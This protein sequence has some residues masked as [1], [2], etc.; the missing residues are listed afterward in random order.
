[1]T[2]NLIS[3][4]FSL[5]RLLRSENLS[6]GDVEEIGVF[7]S[8]CS[9][10]DWHRLNLHTIPAVNEFLR[11]NGYNPNNIAD[12]DRLQSLHAR[13]VDYLKEEFQVTL[14]RVLVK[15]SR[16]QNIFLVASGKSHIQ[17]QACTL[18][19]VLHVLNHLDAR[20]LFIR[21]PVPERTLFEEVEHRVTDIVEHMRSIGFSIEHFR[22]SHK[23]RGSTLTKVLSKEAPTAAQVYDRLRFRIVAK[24]TADIVPIIYFL[25]KRLVPFNYIIPDESRNNLLATRTLL[26]RVGAE[27]DLQVPL[28]EGRYKLFNEFTHPQFRVISFVADIPHRV[29]RLLEDIDDPALLEFGKIVFIPVEFQIFDLRTW[30]KNEQGPANHDS[31]KARQRAEVWRRLIGPDPDAG[32]PADAVI[33]RREK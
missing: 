2:E 7:L 13:T 15:P 5:Q 33:Q 25:K 31:Y 32:D 4:D 1:M 14:P 12:R 9:V 19:K 20:E 26:P 16:F 23:T 10:I 24:E 30:E 17:P 11:V 18:M 22:C 27:E 6:A 21:L 28:G 3:L 8:G 29:D